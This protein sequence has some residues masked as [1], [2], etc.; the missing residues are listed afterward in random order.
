[1]TVGNRSALQNAPNTDG[2][3]RAACLQRRNHPGRD[4]RGFT[5]IEV[6]VAF[7]MLALALTLLLGTLSGAARQVRYAEDA[8]RAALHAQTLLDQVGIGEPLR[9][10]RSD[11]ELDDGRYRW[12]LEVAPWR[13]PGR[14]DVLPTAGA[15]QLMELVLDIEWGEP[16]NTAPRQ[17]LQSRALRL[18]IPE[19]L[20]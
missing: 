13:D 7:M 9:A 3:P 20:P 1:M 11:G 14:A 16:V 15:P 4:Q 5:L 19:A 17:R 2:Q 6:I 18:T 10:G 8:G 12:S